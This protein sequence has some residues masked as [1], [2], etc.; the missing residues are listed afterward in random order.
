MKKVEIQEKSILVR[1]NKLFHDRMNDHEMYEATRGVWKVGKRR[2]NAELAF[3]LYR[4]EVKAIY[5]IQS[6]HPAGST[7][8]STRLERDINIEGRWEFTGT[9]A[10]D[11]I[12]NKYLGC[13]VSH[14]FKKGNS[15]P[16]LYINC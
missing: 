6:W 7:S 14:Y 9:K 3:M 10:E 15:N 11:K 13:D 4:G 2:D 8:Y 12:K 16:I 1:V 5:K